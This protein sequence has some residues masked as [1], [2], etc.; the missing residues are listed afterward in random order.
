MRLRAAC[1]WPPAISEP[2]FGRMLVFWW[3]QPRVVSSKTRLLL[4]ADD[5]FKLASYES[6]ERFEPIALMGPLRPCVVRGSVSGWPVCGLMAN[7]PSP[8]EVVGAAK[9]ARVR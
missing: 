8:P 6:Y 4:K 2:S 7:L 5:H 3:C 1:P 9:R